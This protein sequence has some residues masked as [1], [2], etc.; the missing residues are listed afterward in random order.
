MTTLTLTAEQTEGVALLALTAGA[1]PQCAEALAHELAAEPEGQVVFVTCS[2]V[3]LMGRV[4]DG[5]FELRRMRMAP[6]DPTAVH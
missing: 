4:E 2:D 3:V 6:V 1:C 5:G